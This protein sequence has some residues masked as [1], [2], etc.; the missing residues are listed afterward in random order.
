MNQSKITK[1]LHIILPAAFLLAGSA[2]ALL[3]A[4]SAES[5]TPA[6]PP[7]APAALSAGEWKYTEIR[8]IPAVE[9]KQGVVADSQHLYV[10][11]NHTIGK[12]RKDT[13]E[14]VGGWECPKGDPLIHIN[15][16]LMH[17]GKLYGAHSNSP[18]VPNLSS[19]EIWDPATMRHIGT[20]SFGRADGSLT[21]L[22]RHN[23]RWLACFVHYRTRKDGQPGLKRGGE[24]DRGP[25]WSR[26]VE[27]D[28]QWRE[29]GAWAFPDDLT[30][31]LGVRGFAMS[32]GLFG[33][34]GFLYVTGHDDEALY[35][36]EMPKGGPTLKWV[37]T[38][39]ISAKGQAFGWDP[40]DPGLFYNILRGKRGKESVVIEGR[41]THPKYLPEK[42]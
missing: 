39:P 17:D 38:I 35:L 19:V 4:A 40:D 1:T 31:I 36:L 13:G 14:R 42:K 11:D 23:D 12:Y 41:I 33:P 20:H 5:A 24:P 26:L 10:I 34:G 21:W 16:G 6:A 2:T 25:E 32:A 30:K 27:Y 9:A 37:A 22:E 15:A 18:G 29:T 7:D 8:R 28:D 3:A